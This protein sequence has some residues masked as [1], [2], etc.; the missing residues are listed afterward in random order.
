[1][2]LRDLDRLV[3]TKNAAAMLAP[4]MNQRSRSFH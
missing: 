3:G 1:L 4:A 2:L